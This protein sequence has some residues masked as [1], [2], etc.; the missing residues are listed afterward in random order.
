MILLGAVLVISAVAKSTFGQEGNSVWDGVYSVK[1][2][3]RGATMYLQACAGCHAEDLRG[4]SNSPG[5]RGVS[6]MFLWEARSLGELLNEV[7]SKMPPTNPN[8]LSRG[9]YLDIL[10][11]IMQ[12]NGFPA[13]DAELGTEPGTLEQILITGEP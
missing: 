9:G 12:V 4:D 13:G 3:D 2:A 11:Y 6:F 1:Q 7:R 8:S 10:A 5:L